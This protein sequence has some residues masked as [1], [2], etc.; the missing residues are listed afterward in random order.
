MVSFTR[1]LAFV[2][3]GAIVWMATILTFSM[4]SLAGTFTAF[5]P[6]VYIRDTGAPVTVT[7][8]FTVLNPN[9]QYTL[10]VVNGGLV[11]ATN[12]LV[13]STVITVNGVVVIAP[14]DLN[15]NVNVVEKP[16]T[17]R[18]LS[19][20]LRIPRPTP[21]AGTIPA[22]SWPSHAVTRLQESPHAL[23]P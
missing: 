3:R 20:R 7:G 21:P 18:R 22:S 19:R 14:N 13:S 12:D 4:P 8:T 15:Q 11:D 2:S 17:L 23:P 10:R 16:V 5:G 6:Q 9:T 1:C